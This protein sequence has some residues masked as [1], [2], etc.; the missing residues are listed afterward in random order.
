MNV[1]PR[2]FVA[3][4]FE[5]ARLHLIHQSYLIN[6]APFVRT[7]LSAPSFAA[8]PNMSYAFMRSFIAK[9]WVTS[10]PVHNASFKTYRHDVAKHYLGFFI[11][12]RP[13]SYRYPRGRECVHR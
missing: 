6:Q 12:S 3:H 7:T 4:S 11:A 8:F 1:R 10:L 2:N 9:R 13:G 5:V